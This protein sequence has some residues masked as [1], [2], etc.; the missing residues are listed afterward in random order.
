MPSS[1]FIEEDVEVR[2]WDVKTKLP[3]FTYRNYQEAA[4]YLGISNKSIRNHCNRKTRVFCVR[5]QKEICFR[6]VKK[7]QKQILKQAA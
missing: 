1:K 2:V 6:I 5:L 3:I 7:E 4:K